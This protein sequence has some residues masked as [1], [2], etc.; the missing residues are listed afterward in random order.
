MGSIQVIAPDGCGFLGGSGFYAGVVNGYNNSVLGTGAGLPTMNSYIGTT[1]NTPLRNLR[2]GFAWDRLDADTSVNGAKVNADAWSLAGYLSYQA[3]EK[4]STHLRL[5]YVTADVEKPTSSIH[6]GIF[7]TT[8][9]IQ[10]DLWQ[11]VLSRL[12]FRWDAADHGNLFGG[13]IP[14]APT[15]QNAFLLAANVIYKF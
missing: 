10:Y 4:L 3:T 13:S 7:A 12:E 14:G 9:T 15:R 11:N 8:A 2:V 5:D 6:N 1:L